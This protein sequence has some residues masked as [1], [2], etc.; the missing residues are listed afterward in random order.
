MF[1]NPT[2]KIHHRSVLDSV[3]FWWMRF[4][5]VWDAGFSLV[6]ST[7]LPHRCNSW[8]FLVDKQILAWTKLI[9]LSKCRVLSLSKPVSVH[10]RLRQTKFRCNAR[11]NY[12][13]DA[14]N[15]SP[16]WKTSIMWN[17]S[18]CFPSGPTFTFTDNSTRVPFYGKPNNCIQQCRFVGPVH[19]SWITQ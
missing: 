13:K 1:A 12:W 3:C 14:K 6:Y 9:S 15:K 16:R 17:L 2:K 5:I 4:G 19:K 11:S 7:D 10:L 8:I 18:I